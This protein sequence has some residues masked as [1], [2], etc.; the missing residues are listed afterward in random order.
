MALGAAAMRLQDSAAAEAAGIAAR[1]AAV[2]AAAKIG[3][4]MELVS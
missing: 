3:I 1:N 2:M 4:C